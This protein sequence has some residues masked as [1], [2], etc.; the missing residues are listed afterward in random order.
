MPNYTTAAHLIEREGAHSPVGFRRQSPARD[1]DGSRRPGTTGRCK[2]EG[3]PRPARSR[4]HAPSPASAGAFSLSE[5]IL[6]KPDSGGR[7]PGDR[8]KAVNRS[9]EIGGAGADWI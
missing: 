7:P 8:D 2:G 1:F 9:S 6:R 5:K 4:S 3:P